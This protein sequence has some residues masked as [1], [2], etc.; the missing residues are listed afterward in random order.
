LSAYQKIS[1]PSNLS[2]QIEPYFNF[3]N[4]NQ[5]IPSK[6]QYFNQASLNLNND[7]I[8]VNVTAS[9]DIKIKIT[10]QTIVDQKY[11]A[12]GYVDIP[13][14]LHPNALT[15]D[16]YNYSVN[17]FSLALDKPNFNYKVFNS[18]LDNLIQILVTGNKS[19]IADGTPFASFKSNCFGIIPW[20]QENEDLMLGVKSNYTGGTLNFSRGIDY[21]KN[22]VLPKKSFDVGLAIFLILK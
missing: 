21:Y 1:E 11:I 2:K 20:T 9:S 5:I 3:T 4:I 22:L 10:N 13:I 8:T 14:K 17:L 18:T 12:F 19:G 15:L 7:V 6:W 16:F